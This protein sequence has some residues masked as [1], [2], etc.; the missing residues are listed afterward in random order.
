MTGSGSGSTT[1]SVSGSM[2]T[3]SV[4]FA[5]GVIHFVSEE[6]AAKGS[7]RGPRESASGFGGVAGLFFFFQ[8]GQQI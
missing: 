2:M 1:G 4:F 8:K 7:G 3:F 5:L 6:V